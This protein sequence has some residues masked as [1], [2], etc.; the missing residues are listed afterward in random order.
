VWMDLSTVRYRWVV[1]MSV[2]VRVGTRALRDSGT[3]V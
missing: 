2:S 1:E 3:S